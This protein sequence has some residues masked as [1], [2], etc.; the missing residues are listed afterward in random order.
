MI[1]TALFFAAAAQGQS[2]QGL[3][4]LRFGCSQITVERL[5]PLVNPGMLGTPHVHQIVRR[6]CLSFLRQPTVAN[7]GCHTHISTIFNK[8]T[9]RNAS[10]RLE[11]T[12]S[13]PAWPAPTSRSLPPAQPAAQPMTFQTTGPQTSTSKLETALSSASPRSPTDCSSTTSSL[14]RRRAVWWCTT[15]RPRRTQ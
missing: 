4:H 3:N 15:S 14:H 11:A 8:L 2:L 1:W 12:P 10:Y 13:T 5:D 7:D 9:N 6:S